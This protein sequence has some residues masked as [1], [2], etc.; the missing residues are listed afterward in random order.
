MK[1]AVSCRTPPQH[2]RHRS[3]DYPLVLGGDIGFGICSGLRAVIGGSRGGP[4]G[5]PRGRPYPAYLTIVTLQLLGSYR[6]IDT[7]AF[8]P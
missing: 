3:T 5:G 7:G 4:R 8:L 2:Q 1:T 6:L